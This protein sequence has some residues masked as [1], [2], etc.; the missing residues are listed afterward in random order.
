MTVRVN[1]PAFNI[2]EKLSELERPIGVKGNE[3]MG[4]ETAQEAG[5]LLGV[6]RKNMVINGQ[7][8]INQRNGTSSYTIPHATGGSYGGPDR[9]AINEATNGSVSVNMD[10]DPRSTNGNGTAVQEFSKAMQ[11]A[12]TGADSSVSGNENLH[13]FQN[14]EGYYITQLAWG[15]PAAK[16]VT[17]SFWVKTNL[18]GIYCVGIENNSTNRSCIKE[19]TITSANKW[20]KV[21]LTFPGCPDGT[22]EATNGTGIRLRFCLASGDTYDDGVDGVWGTTDELTTGNQVN[23]MN[24]T[25]NRY[26]ITGVQLEA[27]S[28]ATA[29][30]HRTY[31]EE[32][33][34]CQRYYEKW[35]GE[36]TYNWYV[37]HG[38]SSHIYLTFP[39]KV[40]K[41]NS[42]PN[43][44]GGA[45]VE[46]ST[47][48]AAAMWSAYGNTSTS[49]HLDAHMTS[50]PASISST[51][52]DLSL[53]IEVNNT[54]YTPYGTAVLVGIENGQWVAVNAEL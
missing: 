5:A 22:W 50:T 37:A 36:S 34:L 1:K 12:C 29:F 27:G 17:L 42:F 4:A 25:S 9:W 39:Y 46:Y 23:F 48:S 19:Y 6:G 43:G 14:I 53:Y 7:M 49:A 35:Q 26:F 2:R 15:T 16:P 28:N 38:Y 40:P 33:M 13:F 45:T 41:R 20:Q 18:T 51:N 30:E 8:W 31:A 24:S 47:T 52:N 54:T 3:L 44:S 10:G 32:L 21:V 11:I